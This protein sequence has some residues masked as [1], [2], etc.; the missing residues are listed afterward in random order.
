MNGAPPAALAAA[1]LRAIYRVEPAEGPFTLRIGEFSP[2]LQRWHERWT[3]DRSAFISAAN[4]LSQP[5]DPEQ[6]AAAHE[7]LLRKLET[8]GLHSA[9]GTGLDPNGHWIP[10]RSVLV[11]GITKAEALRL[12]AI[13][14]QHAIVFAEADAVPRLCW[15]AALSAG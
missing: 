11:A 13:F 14:H 1:Y 3:V 7:R 12:A 9:P 15:I 2:E 10:E 5:T 4:P 6:N 8:A